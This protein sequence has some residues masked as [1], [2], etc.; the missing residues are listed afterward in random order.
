MCMFLAYIWNGRIVF[1]V[2]LMWSNWT[3]N[4]YPLCRQNV[5]FIWKL[6]FIVKSKWFRLI[7]GHLKRFNHM[8]I[9]LPMHIL[10]IFRRF[11]FS[12]FFYLYLLLTIYIQI[13]GFVVHLDND[14]VGFDKLNFVHTWNE[15][16]WDETRINNFS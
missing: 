13:P 10:R 11:F 4:S 5:K 12:L 16:E 6:D 3:R 8:F 2:H 15:L 9:S 7:F 1:I 14:V